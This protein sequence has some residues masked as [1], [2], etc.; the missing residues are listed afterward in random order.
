M[1]DAADGVRAPKPRRNL[2]WMLVA[3]T[4]LDVI[5]QGF[6]LLKPHPFAGFGVVAVAIMPVILSYYGV[7]LTA[8]AAGIPLAIAAVWTRNY[9]ALPLAL[10][11]LVLTFVNATSFMADQRAFNLRDARASAERQDYEAH[12]AACT[13]AQN[14]EFEAIRPYFDVPR[15]AVAL[16]GAAE[17]EFDNGVRVEIPVGTPREA[18]RAFFHERL[19]GTDVQIEL[20]PPLADLLYPY[21]SSTFNSLK[22]APRPPRYRGKLLIGGIP[23]EQATDVARD[24]PIRRP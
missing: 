8:I 24:F 10:V 2:H 16:T 11:A 12:L 14:R 20:Q 13:A 7:M 15:K 19:I 17:I 5:V 6:G 1:P 23:I 22:P 18:F 21:C 9:V 3:A 4:A